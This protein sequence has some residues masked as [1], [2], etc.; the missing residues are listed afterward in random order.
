[1]RRAR[2]A[3]A[4][5]TRVAS[6]KSAEAKGDL[7]VRKAVEWEMKQVTEE[8]KTFIVYGGTVCLCSRHKCSWLEELYKSQQLRNTDL[9]LI[10]AETVLSMREAKL[11]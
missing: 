8:L 2:D 7:D 11:L 3:V 5:V 9:P 4:Y 6:I 10:T 1:M